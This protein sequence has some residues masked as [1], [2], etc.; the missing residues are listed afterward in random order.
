MRGTSD[1]DAVFDEQADKGLAVHQADG[2][3]VRPASF[4]SRSR[5]EV[6]GRDD[7]TLLVRSERAAY[8]LDDRGLDV[9]LPPF[10]LDRH[11]GADDLADDQRAAHVNTA[12]A[13]NLRDL[14]ILEAEG[15]EHP[16]DEGLEVGRGDGTE[17]LV[18][19]GADLL[20]V[21]RDLLRNALGGEL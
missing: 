8:L 2:E 21:R 19:L 20:V 11:A 17:Q 16:T 7:E 9:L 18:Q 10:G 5:G 6:A 3:G 12:V 14:D 4:V 13:V 1:T 15:G